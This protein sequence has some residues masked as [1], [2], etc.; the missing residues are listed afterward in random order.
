MYWQSKTTNKIVEADDHK[1][2]S[3]GWRKVAIVPLEEP[4]EPEELY[5][6]T[7]VG[8]QYAFTVDGKREHLWRDGDY[9]TDLEKVRER[10]RQS[11]NWTRVYRS[12]EAY[13]QGQVDA[14]NQERAKEIQA[15][16]TGE[17]TGDWISEGRARE[18][19]EHLAKAGWHR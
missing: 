15:D 2:M 18:I 11:E 12:L 17:A 8:D 10:L 14:E 13:I 19:A 5:E 9:R 4:P 16:L 1:L 7:E 6:V 3:H